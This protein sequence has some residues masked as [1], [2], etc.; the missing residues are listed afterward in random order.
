MHFTRRSFAGLSRD[1]FGA[2]LYLSPGYL[3]QGVGGAYLDLSKSFELTARLS[4]FVHAG[5]LTPLG[6]SD[7][8]GADRE[9]L[10]LG[11]GASWG[12]RH[13]ELRLVWTGTFPSV[14]YPAGYRQKQDRVVLSATHF[15]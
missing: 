3:D 15:F 4:V 11:A 13:G 12:F 7:R 8:P 10:D 5:A 1:G 9:R 6:E 2:R 14:E